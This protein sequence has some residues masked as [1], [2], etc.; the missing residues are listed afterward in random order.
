MLQE[1][2]LDLDR[3]WMIGDAISDMLAARHAGCRGILVR[4]GLG[5]YVDDCRD[6]CEFT[7]P[8]ISAASELILQFEDSGCPKPGGSR[9]ERDR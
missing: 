4:T 6:A 1:L 2:D 8:D 7:V 5:R 9:Q 3:S